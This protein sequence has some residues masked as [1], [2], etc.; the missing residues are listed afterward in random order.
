L[1]HFFGWPQ[2]TS[3]EKLAQYEDRV[4]SSL[5]DR[6][7]RQYVSINKNQ[8]IWTLHTKSLSSQLSATTPLVLLHG[9]GTGAAL[10]LLYLPSMA[11]QRAVY[12]IDMLGFGRSSRGVSFS[13]DP[14]VAE[15]EFVESLE[16]WRKA[17]G[18]D[19]FIL[20]GH[21]F[22]GFI[23]TSYA[24][25]YPS[26]VRHLVLVNPWGFQE[27]RQR[28][29][30]SSG[31][32]D[33]SLPTPL[34]VQ[35]LAFALQPFNPFS[36]LRV[37]GSWGPTLVARFKPDLIKRFSHMFTDD[38]IAQY[39]YHWNAQT[40]SGEVAF[41][42]MSHD[43][44]WARYPMIERVKDVALFV[45][46]TLI[47]GSRSLADSS[48]GQKIQELRKNSF[49]DTHV[50]SG[51]GHFVFADK[52]DLFN[53]LLQH[54]CSLVDHRLDIIP[55]PSMRNRLRRVRSESSPNLQKL[56]ALRRRRCDSQRISEEQEDG[57]VLMASES[58]VDI[59]GQHEAGSQRPVF[60]VSYDEQ[61]NQ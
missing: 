54:T 23:A 46:M 9:V 55:A 50:V 12:A 10:W 25:R 39:I 2:S 14:A 34:W 29:V 44:G 33:R 4:L 19:T 5:S 16:S 42:H 37:A 60:V 22:G 41:K 21:C 58:V 30:P 1:F 13:V 31:D 43:F 18:L 8:Y 40:P 11:A 7:G 6:F 3:P 15:M 35:T 20:V 38:T 59:G 47:Y 36:I 26:R 61:D 45:P 28:A 24:I 56:S 51:A 48:I 49:V 32:E 27:Y 17:V 57:S 52:S 53:K